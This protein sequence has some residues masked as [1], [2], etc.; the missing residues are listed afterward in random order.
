M[1]VMLHVKGF[2]IVDTYVPLL[3]VISE[4]S[5]EFLD[6][7]E[8]VKVALAW[9]LIHATPPYAA[10]LHPMMESATFKPEPKSS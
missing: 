1:V 3:V 8:L 2:C 5:A 10:M 9:S 4:K 7:I 6:I